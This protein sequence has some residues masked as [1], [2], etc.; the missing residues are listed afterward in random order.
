VARHGTDDHPGARRGRRARLSW[1]QGAPP[2]NV[3][4]ERPV[5]TIAVAG[6]PAE[7]MA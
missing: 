6:T 3:A 5:D 1:R 7:N 2:S 4:V